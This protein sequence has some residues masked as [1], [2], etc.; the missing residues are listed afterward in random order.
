VRAEC[1][2]ENC[3]VRCWFGSVKQPSGSGSGAE[4]AE[5]TREEQQETAANY[6]QNCPELRRN[7]EE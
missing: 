6:R 5:G 7:E 2:D 4:L 1:A 3:G